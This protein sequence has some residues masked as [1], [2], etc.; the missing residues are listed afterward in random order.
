M[1]G[2]KGTYEKKILRSPL[3]RRKSYPASHVPWF[4]ELGYEYTRTDRYRN[5]EKVVFVI[6]LKTYVLKACSKK[7][8]HMKKK[9]LWSPLECRQSY[10]ASHI[11]WIRELGYKYMYTDRY[12]NREKALFVF[13]F[14]SLI[15]LSRVTKKGDI[16][17]KILWSPYHDL[18]S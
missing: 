11:P 5:R 8:G 1:F 12:R 10:P 14:Q 3:E 18:G 7:R 4:R 13:L 17:R 2:K 15:F 6:I 16:W 9:I